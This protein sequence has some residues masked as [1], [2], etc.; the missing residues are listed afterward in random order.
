MTDQELIKYIGRDNLTRMAKEKELS[1]FFNLKEAKFFDGLEFLKEKRNHAIY[2]PNIET[3]VRLK[4]IN[5]ML[6]YDLINGN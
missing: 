4:E 3:Q 1:E 5:D 2:Q 6:F